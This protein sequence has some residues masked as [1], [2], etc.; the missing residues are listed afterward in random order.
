MNV[1]PSR[2]AHLVVVTDKG[3]I[4]ENGRAFLL[5]L[6]YAEDVTVT[7]EMPADVAGMVSAVTN[8]AKIF[9]PMADLVDLAKERER[10]EKELAKAQK[11]YEGQKQKLSNE[12][13]L[14]RAPE[15]VVAAERERLEK[16]EALVANLSESLSKLK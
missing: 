13:F 4:F 15:K 3:T 9:M 7:T 11:E 16:A 12:K 10:I 6:A 8:D 5:K 14:A 1:P 2:K